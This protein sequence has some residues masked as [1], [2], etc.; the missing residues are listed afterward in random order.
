MRIREFRRTDFNRLWRID[1]ECFEPGISY[2]KVELAHYMALRGAFTLVAEN[3]MGAEGRARP[4]ASTENIVGFVVGQRDRRG[5]G[6]IVTIDVVAGARRLGV[7]TQLMNA[8][9]V[10]LRE[11]GCDLVYLE[12]AVNNEAALAFYQRGGYSVLKTLPRYYHGELDAFLLAK[13][14]AKA[15][16]ATGP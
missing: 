5:M 11:L 7:A 3:E 6:H 8:A 9:E 12:A 16:P 13:K 4:S 14:F 2:T 15:E 10:R 1:Q